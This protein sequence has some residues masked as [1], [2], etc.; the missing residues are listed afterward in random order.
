MATILDVAN[1]ANVSTATVS[2]VLNGA[3]SVTEEKIQRVMAAIEKVG[4]QV[5]AR[6]PAAVRT[7]AQ[8]ES[9]L[10]LTISGNLIA[11]LMQPF[12]NFAEA[13][14]YPVVIAYYNSNREFEHLANLVS[15]LTPQIAGILL[16][17]APNNSRK[18][19]ALLEPFPLVQIGAPI[20]DRAPNLV[21]YND[22]IRMT[23][24]A[25]NHLLAQGCRK[26]G[27]LTSETRSTAPLLSSGLR[28]KGYYLAL[29]DR[30][31]EVDPSCV[32]SVDMS[33]DGG[34]EGM[35]KLLERHPDLDGVIGIVDSVA[36]GAVYAIRRSGKTTEDIRVFSL[37]S[38]EVWDFDNRHFPYID[39]NYEE[40]A[41]TAFQVLRA[42]ILGEIRRDYRVVIP[43]MLCQTK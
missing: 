2:R 41:A 18:L 15:R 16:I 35:K 32:E 37:D 30:Q 8:G 36:Q 38:S 27:L 3:Y 31:M 29:L 42:A 26:I 28:S 19:Q 9:G 7:E 33:I 13:E 34:Y 1:E 24:D 25:T 12:Q 14:G 21:V 4:Y 10:I 17:N 20:M 5:P 23:E 22:E 6:A 39:P 43:H 40:M 11:P